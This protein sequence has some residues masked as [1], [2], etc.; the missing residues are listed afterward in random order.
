[1]SSPSAELQKLVRALLVA[2]TAVSSFVG[3]RVYDMPPEGAQ[4]PY[5]AFGPSDSTPDDVDCIDCEN[6]SLQLDV[7]TEDLGN[8][9]TCREVSDA[10]K[11]ALHRATGDLGDHALVSLEVSFV[12]VV[13][14]PQDNITHGIISLE[15]IVEV[16]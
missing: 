13:P 9:K 15:A 10:T 5:I 1:M 3:G 14:D 12:R 16:N 4:F 7:W 11:A 2:D 6:I 8:A